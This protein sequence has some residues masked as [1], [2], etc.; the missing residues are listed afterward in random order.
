MMMKDLMSPHYHCPRCQSF[1]VKEHKNIIFCPRCELT[2]DKTF[3]RT[4]HDED[5]LA[6]EELEGIVD[7]FTD[8]A[9]EDLGDV[10]DI[11]DVDDLRSLR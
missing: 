6:N 2:F 5:I 4:L 8:I 10:D 7:V 3:L 11:D 9:A 1:Q